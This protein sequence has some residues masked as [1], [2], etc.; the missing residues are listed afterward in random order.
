LKLTRQLL[1]EAKIKY[2]PVI[3]D[4]WEVEDGKWK[5]ENELFE[6][7]DLL[8]GAL[9]KLQEDISIKNFLIREFSEKKYSG[10]CSSLTSYIEGY[11]AGDPANTSALSFYKEWQSEDE[12][13]YRVSGGYLSL[14]EFLE[15]ECMNAGNAIQLSTIVKR[16]VW[17]KGKVEVTDHRNKTYAA[18]KI[19]ITVPTGVW[20][21]EASDKASIIFMPEIPDKIEAAKQLGNGYAIKIQLEFEN[22]FWENLK[23]VGTIDLK[24]FSFIFS[25]ET[26]G[27]WWTQY[28]EHI[29]LLT[30]W[31]AGPEAGELKNATHE[32]LV[33][34]AIKS[35]ASI[36]SITETEIKANLKST[37]TF[38]W[39]E[40]PF[41]LGGY[42]YSTLKS[43]NA[44]KILSA[45]VEQTLFFAG[46]ALYEGTET[47]T[48]EAALVSGR[49]AA[50]QI[51]AG[52]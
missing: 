49:K 50:A 1:N 21:S 6:N 18:E 51:L 35:L 13:Q 45:P 28:P 37:Q 36:F 17:S 12:N 7:S 33:D 19:L 10:L 39:P 40:D 38:N 25:N 11:Y 42:S 9:G 16:I 4:M 20:L 48:V 44:R 41:T 8:I 3:G 31:I 43:K 2:T 32:T 29:P 52:Q 15:N 26:V 47:G 22:I 34:M 27:T 23:P 5:C 46:E 30:G 14:L 24:Q